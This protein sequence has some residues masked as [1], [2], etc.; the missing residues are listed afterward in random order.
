MEKIIRLQDAKFKLLPNNNNETSVF[1]EQSIANSLGLISGNSHTFKINKENLLK[2][3]AFT[4]SLQK[5]IY[6][7][8][9]TVLL[10]DDWFKKEYDLII[11][12]FQTTSDYTVEINQATGDRFY[13]KSLK[14]SSGLNIRNFLIQDHFKIIFSNTNNNLKI[15]YS[16]NPYSTDSESENIINEPNPTYS[17]ENISNKKEVIF[18]NKKLRTIIFEAFKYVKNT[19]GEVNAIIGYELKDS[20]IEGRNFKGLTLPEY[21][22]FEI[23]IGLFTEEQTSDDLKSSNTS[24]FI[25]EKIK[26]LDFENS[27]FTSQW[28]ESNGR[29]LSLGNFNKFLKDVSNNTLEIIK[30]DEIFQL[31][32]RV[33]SD[34]NSQ[35]KIYYGAPGTGKSHRADIE[36]NGKEVQKVTFH[37]DYD[38]HTFVGGYKPTM[39]GEGNDA[40]ITYKFVPQI[41]TKTYVDAWKN[42][43]EGN[44]IKTFYLQIEEINRGNCAEIFGD[45]FQLLDR[46][47]DGSSKYEVTA[48][49]ELYKYLLSSDAFGGDHEGIKGGKLRFPSNLKII[50][51]MNT[52]DQS[53]FPMDSA[54]KRRW[55]WEYVPIDYNCSFSDFT[56]HLNNGKSFKWLSFLK[57]INEEIFEITKS[58][59]KQ[60]G[61]W[62]IDAQNSEKVISEST[63]I[64]KVIFYLWNDVFKDEENTIFKSTDG[65]NLT[66]T[67]FF[68]KETSTNLLSDIL[69]KRLGLID[70]NNPKGNP[71]EA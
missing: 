40:K 55:D 52:S 8:Q 19:I 18:S 2:S 3:L 65:K 20:T 42:F 27:Y 23:L 50:A 30:E 59:D 4:Y 32:K 71:S 51:T 62:F 38:Y 26:T 21:F 7:K 67:T 11:S 6:K 24:R 64:N 60:I 17:L 48:E 46:K 54:F 39:V 53:L 15:D 9:E 37:P 47:S 5:T 44:E 31:V 12:H 16:E 36:T 25:N 28:N 45:L 56:I 14:Q 66:Y 41:F 22:N 1:I 34:N 10:D 57:T 69:E 43:D 63:F 58:Q 70:I 29:G 61:N 33:N 68:E 13:M 49:E 35:N